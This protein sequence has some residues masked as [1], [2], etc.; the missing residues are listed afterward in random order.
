MKSDQ[1]LEAINVLGQLIYIVMT[2]THLPTLCC[3]L[4]GLIYFK[5]ERNENVNIFPLK[6]YAIF[7]PFFVT[8]L[9]R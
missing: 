1:P 5:S 3:R 6:T 8:L 9:P 4:F 7:S 2:M